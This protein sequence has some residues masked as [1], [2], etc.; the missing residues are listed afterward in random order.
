M[1]SAPAVPTGD[2]DANMGHAAAKIDGSGGMPLLVI[3]EPRNKKQ[4]GD[5][6]NK[7][8]ESKQETRN[9]KAWSH[10]HTHTHTH[11]HKHT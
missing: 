6:P 11:T 8:Q 7:K 9:K 2:S 1:G 3:F 5:L 10:T 4:R